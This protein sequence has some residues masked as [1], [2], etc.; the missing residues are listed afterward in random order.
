M[1]W[2]DYSSNLY[3]QSA[4]ALDRVDLYTQLNLTPIPLNTLNGSNSALDHTVVWYVYRLSDFMICKANSD[5]LASYTIHNYGKSLCPVCE[6]PPS[7]HAHL[8]E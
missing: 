3:Q 7:L 6:R 8:G 1:P 4:F 2:T 5:T